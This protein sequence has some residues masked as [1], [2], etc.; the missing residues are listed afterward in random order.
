MKKGSIVGI[1][2]G[3]AAALVGVWMIAGYVPVRGIETPKYEVVAKHRGYEIRQYAPHIVAEATLKG[4]YRETQ[5]QGFRE[6]AGYIFGKNKAKLSISMTAPVL[7]EPA[8]TSEQIAMTAPVLHE[9]GDEP[10]AYKLA[11]VMPSSYTLDTLPVPDSPN[12]VLRQVPAKK[13]A[14][15]RFRG[16]APKKTV[17]RKT[18][19]L[20]ERLKEDGIQAKGVPFV[21]QYHPPWTPPFM[22][23]NEVLVEVD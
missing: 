14:A 6:V 10:N 17:A 2:G 7:H 3:I 13:Y 5:N 4:T 23:Y 15:V 21:A 8:G 18:Q 1:I 22:R 20:L 11:F 9:K 16:Y 12:V 19:W